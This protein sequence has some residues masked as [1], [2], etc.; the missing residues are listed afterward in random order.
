M[1]VDTIQKPTDAVSRAKKKCFES[2]LAQS[3]SKEDAELFAKSYETAVHSLPDPS[4]YVLDEC[5]G[6]FLVFVNGVFSEALSDT[7]RVP[8]GCAIIAIQ[9]A[10][11]SYSALMI[12]QMQHIAK[13]CENPFILANV[14][15]HDE[16]VCILLAPNT[17]H[18]CPLQ[19][20]SIVD[21]SNCC[22]AP[23]VH[24]FAGKSSSLSLIHTQH[25]LPATGALYNLVFDVVQEEN[26]SVLLESVAFSSHS[27]AFVESVQA[28]LKQHSQF[29]TRSV[30]IQAPFR[31]D[32]R[33]R[34]AGQSAD[35]S[36]SG[37]WLS[38]ND[39]QTKT[40][41]RMEHHEPHARS[42]QHFKGVLA[43]HA[44]SHFC[45]QI[46]VAK[47]AQKTE[48]Y[49]LNKNLLLSDTAAATVDPNL[50][51][52]A[53]D[54]KASHGAT[55]GQLEDDALFYLKSR[56][57]AADTAK[58]LLVRGFCKEVVAK[59]SLASLQERAYQ[60]IHKSVYADDKNRN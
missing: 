37:L 42:M 6:S 58:A 44:R 54:V 31:R 57:I 11:R 18:S 36:C 13:E 30:D 23:R 25:V 59:L 2:F 26:S 3:L 38:G 60:A 28:T 22:M 52:F 15:A 40:L 34:L 17:H 43:G 32:I 29:Q 19:I 33:V 16:G 45:G 51:I 8:S 47:K 20:I 55:V 5:R 50:E 9:K 56:G 4:S 48:S 24:L 53:D 1:S 35:A 7:S 27:L 12:A 41:C 49:Q 39:V 21:A 10:Y 46:L 14:A